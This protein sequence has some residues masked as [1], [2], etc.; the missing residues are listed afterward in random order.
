MK[1]SKSSR[2]H[3]FDENKNI[4]LC[5]DFSHLNQYETMC[6]NRGYSYLELIKRE[7]RFFKNL[8]QS[9][10]DKTELDDRLRVLVYIHAD[11]GSRTDTDYKVCIKDSPDYQKFMQTD[12]YNDIFSFVES[13]RF[14]SSFSCS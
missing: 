11:F 2:Y 5:T 8:L 3:N 7:Q 14:F 9:K 13:V 6:L 12:D 10:Y 4:L 1:K